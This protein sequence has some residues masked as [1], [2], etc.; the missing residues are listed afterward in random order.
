MVIVQYTQTSLTA[1]GPETLTSKR[2]KL[3]FYLLQS[4][5]ELYVL[6]FLLLSPMRRLY[7]AGKWGDHSGDRPLNKQPEREEVRLVSAA[8]STPAKQKW[9]Q[10]S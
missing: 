1:I 9:V 3:A 2:A 5:V 6:A 7:G 10:L 4:A 8:Q